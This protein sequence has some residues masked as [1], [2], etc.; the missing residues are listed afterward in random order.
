MEYPDWYFTSVEFRRSLRTAAKFPSSLG[1][2]LPES[3]TEVVGRADMSRSSNL[4]PVNVMS[5]G[6]AAN[7]QQPK[8]AG[9]T[10]KSVFRQINRTLLMMPDDIL[11]MVLSLLTYDEISQL[12]V[13][14]KSMSK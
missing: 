3:D 6:Q 5:L 13:V 2:G 14:R 12:R 11:T 9:E 7:R 8:N 1:L 10:T 4:V